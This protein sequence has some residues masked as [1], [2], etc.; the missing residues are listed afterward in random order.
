MTQFEKVALNLHLFDGDAAAAPQGDA[1]QLPETSRQKAERMWQAER[2]KRGI[3]KPQAPKPAGQQAQT[4]QQ[5]Q[6]EQPK[7]TQQTQAQQQKAQETPKVQETQPVQQQ[8]PEARKAEFERLISTEYRDLF[9]ERMQEHISRRFKRAE[10]ESAQL[11][12]LSPV[13]QAL[14]ARYPD[15]DPT[16]A[17]A[18]VKAIQADSELFEDAAEA[19]GYTPEQYLQV[20]RMESELQK[21]KAAEEARRHEEEMN[22]RI[23]G[24]FQQAEQLKSTFPDLN[25]DAELRHPANGP[26]LWNMLMAGV[27]VEDAYIAV[28]KDDVLGGAMKYTAEQ[29]QQKVTN[30]IMARGMRPTENGSAGAAPAQVKTDASRLT[31][32]DHD[33]IFRELQMGRKVELPG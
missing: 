5:A 27:P 2:E 22:Q 4:E 8:T 3:E 14:A 21:L 17:E 11:A 10:A 7:A 32:R 25:L 31:K 28:H 29:I 26:K 16:D 13:M 23:A 1:P 9:D 15:V 33:R 20:K 19:A 24:W 12:A 6:R 30:D 18:M